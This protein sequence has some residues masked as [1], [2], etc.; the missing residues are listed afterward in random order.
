MP[1][2][3]SKCVLFALR[4]ALAN[5]RYQVDA[6][7]GVFRLAAVLANVCSS[8]DEEVDQSF[9]VKAN[10]WIDS[11]VPEDLRAFVLL[12]ISGILLRNLIAR[13]IGKGLVIHSRWIGFA[14]VEGKLC[15]DGRRLASFRENNFE[16]REERKVRGTK[17]ARRCQ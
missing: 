17:K 8:G 12:A 14:E 3:S 6:F 11:H 1:L 9:S 13:S 15:E 16:G 7:S 5:L 10:F 2:D 4:T